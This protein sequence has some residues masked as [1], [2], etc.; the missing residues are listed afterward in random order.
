MKGEKITG[1][2][3]GGG[4]NDNPMEGLSADLNIEEIDKEVERFKSS[5]EKLTNDGDVKAKGAGMMRAMCVLVRESKYDLKTEKLHS[6][7]E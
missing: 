3:T 2:G 7:F 6:K 1:E 4:S 5:V